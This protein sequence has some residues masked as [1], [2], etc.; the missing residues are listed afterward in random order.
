[1]Q[2]LIASGGQHSSTFKHHHLESQL[3]HGTHLSTKNISNRRVKL[4]SWNEKLTI[5]HTKI[6]RVVFMYSGIAKN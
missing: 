4:K 2:V 6:H 5:I 1:L 3:E